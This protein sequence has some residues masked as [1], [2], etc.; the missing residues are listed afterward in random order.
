MD[1]NA[2]QTPH[3]LQVAPPET[4][5]KFRDK[6]NE[7]DLKEK[8]RE[9]RIEAEAG[10]FGY[11]NLVGFPVDAETLLMIPEEKCRALQTVAFFRSGNELRVG[12][13]D[14]NLAG[15]DALLTEV[16]QQHH[17][18][19]LR[20]QISQHSFEAVAKIYEH[21][22][23]IRK[24]VKGVEITAADLDKY[25]GMFEKF[26]D[27]STKVRDVSLTDVFT[28]ILAGALQ[29]R[30]TDVHIEAE[31]EDVKIRYRVDGV[32]HNVATLPRDTWKRVVNRIKL[33]AG[34][35]INI[36]NKP[37]DGSITI[38]LAQD[39]IDVRVSTLPTEY[40]ESVAMRLLMASSA[41]LT[42]EDLGLQGP[43]LK[44][45]KR[46]VARPSGLL[47]TSGPTG[48]GKTTTL[49]AV[50]NQLNTQDNKIITLEDPVEYKLKGVNQSQVDAAHDYTFA[51]GL[52]SILRQDPDVI[53]VGEIRDLETAE[54]AIQA[55]LTG[56]LV[57]ST[58]HTNNAAQGIPRLLAMGVKPFLL[59]PG[60]NA[61]MA[62]RLVRRICEHC[63]E[64][65]PISE[66]LLARVERSMKGLAEFPD[67]SHMVRHP[68]TFYRGRG[69][70]EC[71]D[72]GYRGRI[73]IFEL[74][75]KVPEI[76]KQILSA[77]ISE[78]EIEEIARKRGMISMVQD[79]I[80]KAL[81]GITTVEEVFRVAEE[82]DHD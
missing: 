1:D 68:F 24:E 42:L 13:V 44:Q 60:L 8:E 52:R 34:L 16:E 10:G 4:E 74:L 47:L 76:E 31:E 49:Y 78:Y 82:E 63:R 26:Q 57:L 37:Q 38:S 7:M 11:V 67:Y 21:L 64:A 6:L 80:L 40:G 70:K 69:C 30:S 5:Q 53:M 28:M 65:T 2:P 58:V 35:K 33:L 18:H 41:D 51:K 72:L 23:H 25:K 48:S 77:Q 55:T 75:V 45:L 12:S 56:H 15:V 22:P 81:A 17:V 9:V 32:L 39:K 59:A 3:G 79:G 66:E 73:G 50:L 61:L 36:E 14:P 43:V 19:V 20:Y 46:E 71:Q 29:A 27:L 54:I 62:Q